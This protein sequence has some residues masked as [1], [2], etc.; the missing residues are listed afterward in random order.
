MAVTHPGTGLVVGPVAR[1]GTAGPQVDQIRFGLAS[2]FSVEL[3]TLMEVAEI[4]AAVRDVP[5]QLRHQCW[6]SPGVSS[7]ATIGEPLYRNRE[8][9]TYY[10]RCAR[11]ENRPLYRHFRLAHERVAAFFEVRYNLPV[12]YAEELAVPGFHVF[13]FD[14]PGEYDGGGWHVDGL[15]AQVPFFAAH[16]DEIEGVVNFTVPF[17]VP[18]GGSGMDLEDDIPGSLRRGG[19]EAVA[20]PYLPGVMTFTESEYWHR[21]GASHCHEPA[22]RRVTLQGHGVRFRDRWVLY[23]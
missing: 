17:E 22:Q 20:V 11:T 15:H 9:F 14:G 5:A 23:W 7:M 12:V 8:R 19:G 4:S 18:D 6:H 2:A 1:P 16:R 3:F 10:T 13:S 21:I